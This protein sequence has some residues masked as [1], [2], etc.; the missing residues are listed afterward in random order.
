MSIIRIEFAKLGSGLGM[1]SVGAGIL[2]KVIDAVEV[3]VT[4]AATEDDDL[5]TVPTGANSLILY[6]LDGDTY[7]RQ[8][9]ADEEE[10]EPA[11]ANNDSH[12]VLDGG[13][14]AWS[15]VP[16]RKISLFER[17]V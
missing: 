3:E 1:D 2:N 16:G 13:Q 9:A 17:T 7:V 6:G 12:L 5:I 4:G 11:A 8:I 14:E 10:P 15:T